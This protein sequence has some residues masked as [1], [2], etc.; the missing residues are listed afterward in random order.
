[1]AVEVDTAC[2]VDRS[3][4]KEH[5]RH[6]YGKQT[7]A[8]QRAPASRNHPPCVF[9]SPKIVEYHGKG[10]NRPTGNS[11]R[12][13]VPGSFLASTDLAAQVAM[14]RPDSV[15]QASRPTRVPTPHK[16]EYGSG[17]CRGEAVD[18]LV[19]RR[20]VDVQPHLQAVEER[21]WNDYAGPRIDGGGFLRGRADASLSNTTAFFRRRQPS[22]CHVQCTLA[23]ACKCEQRNDD[24]R[25]R[26]AERSSLSTPVPTARSSRLLRGPIGRRDV[27][28]GDETTAR[29]CGP[30]C[31]RGRRRWT[32]PGPWVCRPRS[33]RGSAGLRVTRCWVRR[34]RGRRITPTTPRT[35]GRV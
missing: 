22:R 1:M 4:E 26:Q 34:R 16:Y 27:A 35:A 9:F 28:D 23:Q 7:H 11:Q 8:H 15:Q 19:S 17:F 21:R 32:S 25:R 33:R 14:M 12:P 6:G 24:P 29:G 30:H 13:K 5:R 31:R 18:L 3:N 10:D 2:L 20:H